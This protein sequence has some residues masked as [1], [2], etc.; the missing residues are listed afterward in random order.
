MSACLQIGASAAW[1]K[2]TVY[3]NF[4]LKGGRYFDSMREFADSAWDK[5]ICHIEKELL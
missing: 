5:S 2:I 3:G 4:N 1:W